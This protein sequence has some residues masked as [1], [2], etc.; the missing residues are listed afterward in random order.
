MDYSNHVAGFTKLFAGLVHST[1]WREEMHVKVV[2]ITMLA[3]ADRNGDVLASMPGLADAARVSLAQCEDALRRLSSPDKHSRTKDHEGRRIEPCDGGWH[4]LNYIKYR[5]LRDDENRRQQVREAVRRHR[6]KQQ[7]AV[8]NVSRGKPIAEAEAEAD[9]GTEERKSPPVHPG[10][11][12]DHGEPR[13]NPLVAGRRVELERECLALVDRMAKATGEDPIDVMA[14]ASGYQ[15]AATTKLNP[16]TMSDDRL[17]NTVRDLR[18]D[19]SAE[20][21]KRKAVHRGA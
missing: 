21:N 14:R 6:Q 4:L 11:F 3:L 9:N 1:V 16:A 5:N 15:G 10:R 17:A 2:W 20:E 7:A 8:I 13:S 18:A 19:V 12:K